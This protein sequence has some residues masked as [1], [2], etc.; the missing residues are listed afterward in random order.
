[1]IGNDD[2]IRENSHGLALGT[3]FLDRHPGISG[4]VQVG[5]YLNHHPLAQP[6][7]DG[8]ILDHQ[9]RRFLYLT[10]SE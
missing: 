9:G 2:G 6:G 5:G 10:R 1:M 8:L 3:I 4:A 7:F